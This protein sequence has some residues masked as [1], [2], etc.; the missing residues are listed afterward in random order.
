MSLLS[1]L[2]SLGAAGMMLLSVPL[3]TMAPQNDAQGILFL[4]NRQW[5]VSESYEP[6]DLRQAEVPGSVRR[7]REEAAAALEP[8]DV[9]LSVECSEQ[10]IAEGADATGFLTLDA[11]KAAAGK[12]YAVPGSDPMVSAKALEAGLEYIPEVPEPLPEGSWL[13]MN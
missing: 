6:A 10:T 8:Y 1:S 13:S 11:V 4:V 7:M 2:A 3:D 9:T 5:T 12:V